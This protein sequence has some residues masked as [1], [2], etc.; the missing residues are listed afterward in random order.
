MSAVNH[1][2]IRIIDRGIVAHP[3][4]SLNPAELEF[5]RR[6][7]ANM[8]TCTYKDGKWG[9]AEIKP[10]EDFQLHPAAIVFHYGQAVFEGLKAY[11]AK[12]GS[13]LLFRPELNAERLNHSA[14]RLDLPELPMEFLLRAFEDVVRSNKMF[15]PDTPG[16]LYLRPTMIGTEACLGV[17]GAK[18]VLFYII[19]LPSG[20][21]FKDVPMGA[22][23]VNVLVSEDVARA[24]RGGL[25]T[26]KAAANYAVSLKTIREG[27]DIGCAQVLFLD[28]ATG[29]YLEEM[30][31]MN[32]F[33]SDGKKL[34]TP[35]LS[36]EIL[37]GVTRR[38]ILE[39]AAKAGIPVE[40]RKISLKEILTG[41][42]NGTITEGLACGTAAVV[43]GIKSLMLSKSGEVLTLPPAP[44]PMTS[45]LYSALTGIQFG[46]AP[47]EMGWVREVK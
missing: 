23:A 35:E 16:S 4:F 47:D 30:G 36:G 14:W 11:K 22:G 42:K 44:G 26:A 21:Y 33:F 10:L 19:A 13:F 41:I 37:V 45:K 24:S 1:T 46:S 39:Y 29:E 17:R 15:V 25:G 43:T 28:S 20:S 40:E 5:G 8:L 27:K 34:I 12:K 7:A 2:D 3:N 32:V 18:E 38:S 31:G 6:F 9:E